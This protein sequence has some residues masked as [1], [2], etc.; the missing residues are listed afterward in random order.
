VIAFATDDKWVAT[1]GRDGALTYWELPG[2]RILERIPNLG[3]AYTASPDGHWLASTG[4]GNDFK[5]WNLDKAIEWERQHPETSGTW[6][7]PL[8]FDRRQRTFKGHADFVS[9]VAFSPDNRAIASCSWDGQIKIWNIFD[10]REIH[11]LHGHTSG[12]Q[13]ITFSPNARYLYSTGFDGT[14][15]IWDVLTGEELVSLV[16][17]RD[18]NNWLAVTP[19]G[20][21]DGRADAMHEVA[22]RIQ[23]SSPLMPLENYFNDY[24]YAGLLADELDGQ[25]PQPVLDIAAL[26]QIPGLRAANGT[27]ASGFHLSSIGDAVYVCF[28]EKPTAAEQDMIVVDASTCPYA[29]RVADASHTGD[30]VGKLAE[31]DKQY[32]DPWAGHKDG[33][34]GMSTLHV[35]TVGID[36]YGPEAKLPNLPASVSSADALDKFFSA[37]EDSP[38]KLFS[39]VRIWNI[40]PLRNG[41]ATRQAIRERLAE[42][43]TVIKPDDVVFIFLS[44]HGEIPTSG[45][46]GRSEMFVLYPVDAV[47]TEFGS[48]Q[49]SG[50]STAM[51]AD[52][53]REM[54][55]R[56]VVLIVDACQSGGSV[57]SLS[58]IGRIKTET[59]LHQLH[60]EG[61]SAAS[62]FGI[63]HAV[64]VDVI[65]AT[66]PVELGGQ[67]PD[68]VYT[69]L[70]GALIDALKNSRRD[71][72]GR[73]WIHTVEESIRRHFADPSNTSD[74]GYKF[75]PLLS[76]SGADFPIAVAR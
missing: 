1:G 62:G 21:F 30:L 60:I 31:Q 37:Q 35:L 61:S 32:R 5:L 72:A 8:S 18:S 68:S 52:A 70:A 15:R 25:R 49:D 48:R 43:A 63:S 65:A 36:H 44:G 27:T 54:P 26:L 40:P 22:W 69:P 29:L 76:S 9:D 4:W 20:L 46:T 45:K 66:S 50:L 6:T 28:N 38:A 16:V 59:E 10:G 11:T 33:S 17:G 73:V 58:Q 64:G 67:Y 23:Q 19:N 34:T 41:L 12:V 2:G 42:M 57:D 39:D 71:D 24:Y 51:L 53:I 56:R 3:W 47:V 55:A 74:A 7:I 13:S 75:T 14:L